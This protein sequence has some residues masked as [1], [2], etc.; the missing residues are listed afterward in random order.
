VHPLR[1]SDH[2]SSYSVPQRYAHLFCPALLHPGPVADHDNTSTASSAA[3]SSTK[4][5]D[6]MP[7]ERHSSPPPYTAS[8][9]SLFAEILSWS[10]PR[11]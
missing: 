3:A 4:K 10:N 5:S 9:R 7:L 2:S 6:T 1:F 11:T 8:Y